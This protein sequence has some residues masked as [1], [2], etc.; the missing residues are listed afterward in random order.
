MSVTVINNSSYAVNKEVIRKVTELFH[1]S[2][3]TF[4]KIFDRV[5]DYLLNIAPEIIKFPNNF[6]EKIRSAS[7]FESVSL[8]INMVLIDCIFYI[9]KF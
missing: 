7:D 4:E 9:F 8:Y 3:S 5:T 1:I 2:Y 6:Q